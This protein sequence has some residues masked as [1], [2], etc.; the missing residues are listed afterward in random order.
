MDEG[1][2]VPCA[3]G[4]CVS[5]AREGAIHKPEAEALE[6]AGCSHLESEDIETDLGMWLW[7]LSELMH[8]SLLAHEV[9]VK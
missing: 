6:M 4:K 8:V 7:E 2:P 9:F 1:S 3:P 5:F